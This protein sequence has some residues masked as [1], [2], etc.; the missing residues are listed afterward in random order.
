[1]DARTPRNRTASIRE[2]KNAAGTHA[3]LEAI[4]YERSTC[5]QYSLNERDS[6]W[7]TFALLIAGLIVV[8]QLTKLLAYYFAPAAAAAMLH[9]GRLAALAWHIHAPDDFSVM[10][11][12]TAFAIVAVTWLLPISNCAK[13]LWT[14]AA[15]SNHVESLLRPGAMDFL[16]FR[17]SGS[18]LVANVADIYFVLGVGVVA[19]ELIQRIRSSPSLFAAVQ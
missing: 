19:G 15:L 8:D 13:V 16:A 1:M 7:A 11:A 18:V 2:F 12:G 14:A 4:H 5:K 3:R 9:S 17:F 10:T 6:H